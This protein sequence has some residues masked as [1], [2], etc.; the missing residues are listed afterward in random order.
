MS[1]RL[2]GCCANLCCT[3]DA[4]NDHTDCSSLV[5]HGNRSSMPPKLKPITR[6]L[7]SFSRTDL[8]ECCTQNEAQRTL[9]TYH[10]SFGTTVTTN[11]SFGLGRIL[12]LT[13]LAESGTMA[14]KGVDVLD[15]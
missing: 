6:S 12:K 1:K 5:F 15:G 8:P 13:K 14:G 2:R 9:P 7:H 3:E 4:S 11:P 10:R